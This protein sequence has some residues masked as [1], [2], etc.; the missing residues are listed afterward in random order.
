MSSILSRISIF[1]GQISSQAL[2]DVHA[3]S[4]SGVI[5]SNTLDDFTFKSIGVD[6][7]AGT[8]GS[9]L[10]DITCPTFNIISRGSRGL[11]VRFAGQT[12]VHLP[13]TVQASKSSSCF[14]V[15]FSIN[16]AP[17]VSISSASIRFPMSLIAPFGLSFGLKNIFDGEVTICL[18]FDCGKTSKNTKKLTVWSIHETLWNKIPS[19][20][21]SKVAM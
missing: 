19:S 3:Q 12:D 13:Q 18:N 7:V 1:T 5:R 4:S 15:K 20:N 16:S 21:G 9:P 8:A 14:H 11:P 2:Q 17:T 10:S 6:T